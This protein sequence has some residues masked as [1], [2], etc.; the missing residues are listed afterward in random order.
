MR[1]LHCLPV[2]ILLGLG[3][4]RAEDTQGLV[5]PIKQHR[6][7]GVDIVNIDQVCVQFYLDPKLMPVLK[8][9][10]PVTVRV[11]VLNDAQFTGKIIFID[12]RIDVSSG[13]FRIKVLIEN[14]DHK[15]KAGMRA[16]ADFSKKK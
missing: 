15:I 1:L 13:L 11:A 4:L 9:E 14:P 2:L 8:E 3:P 6:V 10:Q 7:A 5:F 16:L 12:P